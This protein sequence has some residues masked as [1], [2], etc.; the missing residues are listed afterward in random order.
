METRI[1][2]GENAETVAAALKVADLVAGTQFLAPVHVNTARVAL[3]ESP[4]LDKIKEWCKDFG[5]VI[6]DDNFV[7]WGAPEFSQV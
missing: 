3:P 5:V 2:I 6:E 7:R 1:L 4:N